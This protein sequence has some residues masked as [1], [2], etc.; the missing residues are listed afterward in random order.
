[1]VSVKGRIVAGSGHF[2]QRMTTYRDVF[3]K[4]VGE[5]L[6]PGSEVEVTFERDGQEIA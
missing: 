3:T 5:K 4:A 1:M 2:R 6:Y